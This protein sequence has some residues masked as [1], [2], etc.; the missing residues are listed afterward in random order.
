MAQDQRGTILV[1]AIICS[2]YYPMIL[3]LRVVTSFTNLAIV[4]FQPLW[5]RFVKGFVSNARC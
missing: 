1:I 4:T 3:A 2:V 5:Q